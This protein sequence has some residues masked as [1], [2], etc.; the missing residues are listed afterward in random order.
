MILLASWNRISAALVAGPNFVVSLPGDPG[1]VSDI[2]NPLELRNFWRFL[3]SLLMAP[4]VRGFVND[5]MF[6]F[7]D[8]GV[9]GVVG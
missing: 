7:G 2:K 1:P 5:G 6:V 4:R 9:I 8:A 3:A